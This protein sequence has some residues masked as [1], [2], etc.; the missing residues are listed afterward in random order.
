MTAYV[1]A[2]A[3]QKGHC[4]ILIL[5]LADHQMEHRERQLKWCV[6]FAQ[7]HRYHESPG[8][9]SETLKAASSARAGI[10]CHSNSW[11]S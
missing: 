7:H 5:D 4:R 3:P 8:P 1:P 11:G 9:N 2:F 6:Y 10:R